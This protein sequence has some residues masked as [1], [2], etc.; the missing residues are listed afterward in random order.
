M[1]STTTKDYASATKESAADDVRENAYRTRNDI[2]GSASNTADNVADAAQT[3]GRKVRDFIDDTSDKLHSTTD[4]LSHEVRDNPIQST[5]IA[6]S[7][8]F[9]LGMLFRR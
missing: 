8:G 4:R 7:A 6:L 9:V 5:L 1:F 2:R 3:A